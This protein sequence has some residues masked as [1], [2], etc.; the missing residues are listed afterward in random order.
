MREESRFLSEMFEQEP[1]GNK[2]YIRMLDRTQGFIL[3]GLF[4]SVRTNSMSLEYYA[5]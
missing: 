1:P 2:C 5:K 3:G 4:Y